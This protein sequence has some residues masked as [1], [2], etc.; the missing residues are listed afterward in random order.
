MN[1]IQVNKVLTKHVKYFQVFY[2]IAL[3]PSRLIKTSIIVINLD[4]HYLPGSH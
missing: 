1:S 3:L 4:K 2:P